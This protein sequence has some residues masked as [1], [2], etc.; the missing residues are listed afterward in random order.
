MDRR[1]ADGWKDR[2]TAGW[3][4]RQTGG[5]VASSSSVAPQTT[6]HPHPNPPQRLAPSPP[7]PTGGRGGHRPRGAGVAAPVPRL[8]RGAVSGAAA[9]ALRSVTWAVSSPPGGPCCRGGGGLAFGGPHGDLE[10]AEPPHGPRLV[11]GGTAALGTRV[12]VRPPPP[13]TE[14]PHP[15]APPSALA[16]PQCG[17]HGNGKQGDA[18]LL[19]AHKAVP[20]A[21]GGAQDTPQCPPE[22]PPHPRGVS[23][24]W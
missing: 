12:P 7:A 24:G 13:G 19:S 3:R 1:L 16:S 6:G 5:A 11:A 18:W 21:N 9:P 15:C 23:R 14:P 10:G 20:S 2:Q 4:D 8:C 17:C 22:P